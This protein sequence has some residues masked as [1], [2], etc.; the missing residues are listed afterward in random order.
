MLTKPEPYSYIYEMSITLFLR[1][2]PALK[3]LTL[4]VS[5]TSPLECLVFMSSPPHTHLV[6]CYIP[7]KISNQLL[8]VMSKT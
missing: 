2:L 5:V 7:K 4:F 6:A 1:C 3:L 8:V